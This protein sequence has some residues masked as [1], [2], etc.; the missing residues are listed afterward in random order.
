MARRASSG[1]SRIHA[2]KARQ[3]TKSSWRSPRHKMQYEPT[4]EVRSAWAPT[5]HYRIERMSFGRRLELTRQVRGLLAK[6]EFHAAGDAPLD[7]VEASTLAM[8]VDQLDWNWGLQSIDGL[9][10][11]NEA[12][13]KESLFH[14]G[15]EPLVHEIL[16]A[17]K[18]ECGLSEEERKN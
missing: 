10:I 11:G 1:A 15:P 9:S 7:R 13:T 18:L 8:E 6:Q 12:A 17:I 5:V 16:A 4:I 14:S 3:T 2:H